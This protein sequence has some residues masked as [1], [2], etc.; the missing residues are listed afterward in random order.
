MDHRPRT[1]PTPTPS[2]SG[3]LAGSQRPPR[4]RDGAGSDSEAALAS[5]APAPASPTD[6]RGL[7]AWQIAERRPYGLAAAHVLKALERGGY[8]VPAPGAALRVAFVGQTTYFE[9]CVPDRATPQLD[10]AFVE[11]R[12]G[13]EI[14]P[15]LRS[16]EEHRPHVV[17]AFRPEL[18]FVSEFV[19]E[20]TVDYGRLFKKE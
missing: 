11:F 2:A 1:P 9:S 4:D 20:S 7:S 12:A 13:A 3:T 8:R 10:P 17:F 16:V 15:M 18:E 6:S 19:C 5:S 14:D